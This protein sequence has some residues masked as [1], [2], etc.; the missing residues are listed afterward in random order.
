MLFQMEKRHLVSIAKCLNGRKNDVYICEDRFSPDRKKYTVWAVKDHLLAKKIVDWFENESRPEAAETFSNHGMYCVSFPYAAKRSLFLYACMEDCSLNGLRTLCKQV[1]FTCMSSKLPRGILYLV[2]KQDG[3]N[4]SQGKVY[5]TC[6]LDLS[7]L[8][9][10][11]ETDNV[12]LCARILQDILEDTGC[13]DWSGYEL[14]Q[15]KNKRAQYQSFTELYQD[16]ASGEKLCKIQGK[17]RLNLF[18][19]KKISV[20]FKIVKIFCIV[21]AIAALVVFLA[22]LCLGENIFMRLFENRFIKIGT[23][24]LLQ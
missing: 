20:V 2:L 12:R 1:V 16:I 5:L 24:S 23:E 3:L 17:Y 8:S 22:N 11:S 15:K 6:Q 9:E 4:V 10:K 21:A 14:L 18:F 19:K 7:E 13:T